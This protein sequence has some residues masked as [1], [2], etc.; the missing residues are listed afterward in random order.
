MKSEEI[1]IADVL[2]HPVHGIISHQPDIK[3]E[4]TE[5]IRVRGLEDEP[6]RVNASDCEWASAEEARDYWKNTKW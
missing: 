3:K 6:F 1:A 5:E 2:K 4:I